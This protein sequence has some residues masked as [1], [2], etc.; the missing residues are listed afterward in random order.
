[1]LQLVT[2]SAMQAFHR[3]FSGKP[4]A[5]T[6]SAELNA[7]IITVWFRI[8]VHELHSPNERRLKDLIP[9]QALYDYLPSENDLQPLLAWLAVMEKAHVHLARWAKTAESPTVRFHLEKKNSMP[10]GFVSKLWE[11]LV[12]FMISCFILESI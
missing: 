5:S 1:M 4:N 9:P 8:Q 7:Q 6:L 2:A 3:L 11:K 12:L 10:F